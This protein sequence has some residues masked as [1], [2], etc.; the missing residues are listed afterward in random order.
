[1][2]LR[3]ELDLLGVL[4]CVHHLPVAHG[5]GVVGGEVL[6]QVRRA[7]GLVVGG[8][9]VGRAGG[10]GCER[11]QSEAAMSSMGRVIERRLST[12]PGTSVPE[13]GVAQ[14]PDEIENLIQLS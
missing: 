8:E 1:V 9:R 13:P 7:A 5:A 12:G 11:R 4:E 3:G 2:D 6:E 10:Q 14:V